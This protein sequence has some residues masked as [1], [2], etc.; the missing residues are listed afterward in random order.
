MKIRKRK[1]KLEKLLWSCFEHYR[2]GH[3]SISKQLEQLT[4]FTS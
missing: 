4:R 3:E 2:Q 1:Q